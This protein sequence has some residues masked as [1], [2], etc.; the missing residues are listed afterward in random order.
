VS[1]SNP[2]GD[3]RPER[4]LSDHDS[5]KDSTDNDLFPTDYENLK[6]YTFNGRVLMAIGIVLAVAAAGTI[7]A[8]AVSQSPQIS[9]SSSP[10][11]STMLGLSSAAK[12]LQLSDK[13]VDR[14]LVLVADDFGWNGSQHG[15]NIRVTQGETIRLSVINAGKMAHNFGIAEVPQDTKALMDRLDN[16][17]VDERLAQISYDQMSAHPCPGCKGVFDNAH[18][19]RF[20]LPG[21]QQVVTFTA[22]KAGVFKYFCMVRGHLWLGMSGDFIVESEKGITSP[23]PELAKE[24]ENATIAPTMTGVPLR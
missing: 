3:S 22:D 5:N 13:K 9:F 24:K 17:P 21:E 1:I 19:M 23:S 20:I 8:M 2:N 15:P 4:D 11:I 14:E 18:I 6:P 10:K 16:L 12:A 7:F